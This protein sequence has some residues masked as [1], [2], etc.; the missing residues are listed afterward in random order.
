M[1][2][3]SWYISA[4]C[5][6]VPRFQQ[7][8]RRKIDRPPS[9][10]Q[11]IVR[12]FDPPPFTRPN[13]LWNSRSF[14]WQ[15]EKVAARNDLSTYVIC[16]NLNVQVPLLLGQNCV[17]FSSRVAWCVCV[18]SWR[19]KFNTARCMLQ[20][21]CAIVTWNSSLKCPLAKILQV[22]HACNRAN[23][24]TKIVVLNV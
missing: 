16:K 22:E 10:K 23:D 1:R 15:R 19:N 12:R 7:R 4:L 13:N 2:Y 20:T 21:N 18:S 8:R 17:A 14:H 6:G 3:S 5:S 9:V 24:K 11:S